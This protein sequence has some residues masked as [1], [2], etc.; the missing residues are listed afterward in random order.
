[1]AQGGLIMIKISHKGEA[2][3]TPNLP[4]VVTAILVEIT[5]IFDDNYGEERD[6]D[7]DLGG[8]IQ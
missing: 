3:T 1:M 5:I 4:S 7:H 2:I 6:V 8:Y